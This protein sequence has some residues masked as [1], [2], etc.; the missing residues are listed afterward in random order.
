MYLLLHLFH[1]NLLNLKY[2]R[3]HF[4]LRNQQHLLYLK[5]LRNH[6]Y[7]MYY[8]SLMYLLPLLFH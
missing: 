5:F 8:L 3:L 1:L 6:L 7:Q 4:G 2:Q